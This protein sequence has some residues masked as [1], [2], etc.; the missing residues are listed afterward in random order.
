MCIRDSTVSGL[1]VRKELE[2]LVPR[3][4]AKVRFRFADPL[5]ME[6]L[7]KELE[8]LPKNSLVLEMGFITD[9]SGRTFGISEI[10]KLFSEHSPVPIYSTYEQQLGF[11][12]VGGKLL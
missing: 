2:A 10:T 9:K 11:G 3:F 12:I 5:T 8:R 7:L 4:G 6:E 1:A